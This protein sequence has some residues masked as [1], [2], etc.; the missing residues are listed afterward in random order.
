MVELA[1]QIDLIE[2]RLSAHDGEL[3]LPTVPKT[4]ASKPVKTVAEYTSFQPEHFVNMDDRQI[5]QF[6]DEMITGIHA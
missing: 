5:L 1:K 6:Q 3:A 2:G 4:T